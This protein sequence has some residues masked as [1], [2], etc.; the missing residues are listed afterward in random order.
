M[1]VDKPRPWIMVVLFGGSA[2]PGVWT[3]TLFVTAL[4]LV[5]TALYERFAVLHYALPMTPFSL[6]GLALSIF[7][8]FRNTTSYDRFWEGRK[9]WGQLVN[10]TRSLTRQILTLLRC[11]A[12]APVTEAEELRALQVRFV[13]TIIAYVHAF[14]RMLRDEDPLERIETLVSEEDFERLKKEE[15]VP[16]GIVQLL[17]EHVAEARRRGWVHEMH[18]PTLETSLVSMTDV[19]GG[20]ERIKATPIPFSYLV[21]LHRIVAV[22]CGALSFA[23]DKE[24]GWGTPLVVM[25]VSYAFFGL[26]AVGDEIED[27]FGR[28]T[29]DLPLAAISRTIER[30]LRRRLGEHPVPPALLPQGTILT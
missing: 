17:A 5:V 22:Y 26:D 16:Y 19:Q 24:F 25:F 7:L 28:D 11:P 14:R 15:N 21:L 2:L 27:P 3:R 10:T 29:H 6:I 1:W 9:L 18:V 13:H 4:S 12:D 30:N 23:I 8:G 20:C